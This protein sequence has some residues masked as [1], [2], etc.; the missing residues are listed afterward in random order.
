MV[1]ECVSSYRSWYD[2]VGRWVGRGWWWS[3]CLAVD[4]GR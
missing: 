4:P 2:L 3:V 1:V